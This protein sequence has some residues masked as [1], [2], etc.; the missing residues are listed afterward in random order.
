M[1]GLLLTQIGTF[2]FQSLPRAGVGMWP[3]CNLDTISDAPTYLLS[4][5][6]VMGHQ[7]IEDSIVNR[8]IGWP[9]PGKRSQ[10]QG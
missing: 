1:T 4:L 10:A 5:L 6:S 9:R 2:L 7:G 8:E 3:D